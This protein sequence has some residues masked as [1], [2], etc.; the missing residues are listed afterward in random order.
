MMCRQLI[1]EKN[2]CHLCKKYKANA[3][4]FILILNSKYVV[5]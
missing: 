1:E 3:F 5:T 4:F 2:V